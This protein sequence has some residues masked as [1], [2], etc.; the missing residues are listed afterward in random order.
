MNFIV[1]VSKISYADINIKADTAEK[2]EEV[3]RK[4][5]DDE[6]ISSILQINWHSSEITD[7]IVD[8]V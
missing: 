3:V 8:A 7:L 6:N 5:L 1:R 2:A 4:A